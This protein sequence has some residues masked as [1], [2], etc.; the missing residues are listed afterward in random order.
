MAPEALE[1]DGL[2][3]QEESIPG[4]AHRADAEALFVGIHDVFSTKDRYVGVVEVR[5]EDVP[6]LG[7][8]NLDVKGE[9]MVRDTGRRPP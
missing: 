3:V 1:V 5:L 9:I 8:E 6:Q 7:V 2:V 4:H